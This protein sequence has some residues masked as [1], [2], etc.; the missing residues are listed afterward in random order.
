MAR[1]DAVSDWSVTPNSNDNVGGIN[2]AEGCA[3]ANLNNAIRTVMAQVKSYSL[4]A[5]PGVIYSAKNS[6]YTAV[7]VDKNTFFR[8]T[9]A[10]TLNL[11]AAATL[12]TNWHC[13]IM[14]DG[15]NVTIDADG[16][17]TIN[18]AATLVIDDGY[19]AF[20]MCTGAAFYAITFAPQDVAE[21]KLDALQPYISVASAATTDIGAIESQNVTITGTTTITSFGTV[22]AGTIRD[23][24]FS[25]ALTLTHNA[26]SLIL[27]YGANITTAARESLRAVSLGSGNWR[28]TEYQKSAL[29]VLTAGVGLTSTGSIASGA[30]TIELDLYTGSNSSLTSYPIGEV[31][32]V[33]SNGT[34]LA[35]NEASNVYIASDDTGTFVLPGPNQG[36][37]LAGLY[38]NRGQHQG[39]D[40]GSFCNMRRIG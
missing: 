25:G 14:A 26:T 36:S 7:A 35:R 18:G 22:A 15:G 33:Q 34:N 37:L 31:L 3:A 4:I 23:V 8:F 2:I 12:L 24:V 9:S 40:G 39:S 19:S 21:L 27:P 20:V 6:D 13:W 17:E 28:V 30:M 16:A 38:R 5:E 10:A 32:F 11:T 1:K 29:P